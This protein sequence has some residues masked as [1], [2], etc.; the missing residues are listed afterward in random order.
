[1]SFLFEN[2]ECF[3]TILADPPWTYSNFGQ[4]KHGAA[5]AHYELMTL[6]QLAEIP[7]A[8]E[9][10]ADDA[11][12]LLWATWPKLDEAMALIARWGFRYV[13]GFPWV[14][15]TPSSGEIRCGIGFYVQ[16]ASEFV[17]VARRGDLAREED[18]PR[19]R[20][21][22]T[23][24]DPVTFYAP[25]GKHSEKPV[26]LH[27]WAEATFPGPRLELFARRERPGWTT[28]GLDLGW[29]LGPLGVER[30]APLVHSAGEDSKP[31]CGS[32]G[33]VAKGRDGMVTCVPCLGLLA[34]AA[35]PDAAVEP[36]EERAP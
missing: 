8:R 1:V 6:D 4:A 31:R 21:L 22:L 17:L 15:T 11:F 28:W 20:G 26:T 12:L 29:R 27:E 3:R 35:S 24:S 2:V 25:I 36:A 34:D 14:K 32:G 10:A 16:S 18:S 7:V 33:P 30:C 19:V 5:R 9:W 23:G 13:T